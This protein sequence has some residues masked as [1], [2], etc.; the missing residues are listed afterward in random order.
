MAT[1]H[2]DYNN[3]GFWTH[4][5]FLSAILYLIQKNLEESE[6][7]KF[8]KEIKIKLLEASTGGYVGCIPNY[9]DEFNDSEKIRYLK[10]SILKLIKE[11]ENSTDKLVSE[12]NKLEIGGYSWETMPKEEIIETAKLLIKLVDGEIETAS[13]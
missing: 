3:L 2:I 13:H 5:R 7:S 10:N 8:L 11:V 12:F 1:S 6:N 4:D 9:I